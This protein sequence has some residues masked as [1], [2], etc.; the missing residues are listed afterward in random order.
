[1]IARSDA[2][3][4]WPSSPAVMLSPNDMNEVVDSFGGLRTVTTNEQLSVRCSASVAEHVS[5]FCP[6]LNAVPV[7]GVQVVVTGASPFNTP[8]G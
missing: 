2:T 1:M 7:A 5:V 8:G 3:E 4:F 6:M